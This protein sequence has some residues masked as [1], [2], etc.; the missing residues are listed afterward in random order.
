MNI[1]QIVKRLD[2]LFADGGPAIQSGLND[3]VQRYGHGLVESARYVT[4]TAGRAPDSTHF[5]TLS[6]ASGQEITVEFKI[7]RF[8]GMLIDMLLQRL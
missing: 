1:G 5:L 3:L 8:A 4:P 2:S 6:S 7:S